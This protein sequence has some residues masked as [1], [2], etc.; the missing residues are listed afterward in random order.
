MQQP[1]TTNARIKIL[2]KHALSHKPIG[3]LIIFFKNNKRNHKAVNVIEILQTII[4]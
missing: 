1:D 3:K 4:E 2:E